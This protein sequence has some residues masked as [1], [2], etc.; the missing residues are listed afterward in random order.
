M[1][2]KIQD[3]ID[4]AQDIVIIQADNPDADSLASALALEQILGDMGKKIH[5]YC[6]V[7]IPTYLRYLQGWDRVQ[8]LLPV[9]FDVG[10]IVDTSAVA[11]LEKLEE[12]NSLRWLKSKPCII[13]DHHLETKPTIDFAQVIYLE[14]AVSTGELIYELSNKLSWK[15]NPL[16]NDLLA[17]SIF[18]DS[19]GLTS[20]GT[21]ARSIA[22]IS[23]LVAQGVNIPA[24]EAARRSMQKK[25]PELLKYKA[26]LLERVGYSP[27]RRVA[28]V[29]IPW[30]D[31]EKYSPEYNPS[32]LVI[33]EMRQVTGVELAVAFKNYPDGRITAK[34]RANYG[35]P[36]AADTAKRFGGGGHP[37]AA[38]FRVTDGRPFNELKAECI[39]AALEL[40]DTLK[41]DTENETV[42]HTH[43]VG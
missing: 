37:Y 35:S 29:S 13:I 10:I 28:H 8:D 20:E 2:K 15:R 19:L 38:G 3:I 18:S 30:E 11:L 23:E 24:L 16:A 43:T 12:N 4:Q 25:S 40:L 6:G 5:L 31:I 21:S 39:Q 1:E 26:Q 32:M 34:L 9:K 22:I 36:V 17:V 42:Q 7:A 27:D 14:K 41:K 33:D